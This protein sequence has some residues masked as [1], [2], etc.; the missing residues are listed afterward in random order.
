MS[1]LIP[2]D[3]TWVTQITRPNDGDK[4][5]AASVAIGLQGLA[6][7]TDF[8]KA[9]GF[10]NTDAIPANSGAYALSGGLILA[11]ATYI[12]F[13]SPT[14]RSYP[15]V[16][17]APPTRNPDSW[18]AAAEQELTTPRPAY[19]QRYSPLAPDAPWLMW[20]MR[21]PAY[22]TLTSVSV[23]ISPAVGAHGGNVPDDQPRLTLW[24]YTSS[25]SGL[26][27][28]IT[29]VQDNQPT[30]TDYETP[31]DLSL[32]SLSYSSW[33]VD[34]CLVIGV[35]GEEGNNAVA[36]AAYVNGGLV[37]YQPRITITR[38]RLGEE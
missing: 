7:R 35:R 17:T 33:G 37:V 32:P 28:A 16:V 38:T 20:M 4:R 26:M 5:D 2:I 14:A 8:L 1:Q 34:D 29:T 12:S 3:P 9:N 21:I 22:S 23:E 10:F 13:A 11:G 24:K 18:W 6:W 15:R 30:Y 27:T 19:K 25:N 31:H 36:A